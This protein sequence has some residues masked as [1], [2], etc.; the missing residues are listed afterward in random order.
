M[1][2]SVFEIIKDKNL[3]IDNKQFTKVSDFLSIEDDFI[4]SLN[5]IIP[6]KDI[7]NEIESIKNRRLLKR[8]L[9][10]SPKT[11]EGGK[12]E[13]LMSLGERP[14]GLRFIRNLISDRLTNV[15]PYDIWIDMPSPPRFPE[16][17]ECIVKVTDDDYLPLT[18]FFPASEW[19]SSYSINKYRG[20]IFCP[21]SQQSETDRIARFVLKEIYNISLNNQSSILAKH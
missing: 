19:S 5:K 11:I 10:L 8:A 1:I 17:A 9:V 20:H 4:Y 7:H 6:D 18:E 3:T 2:R 14:E 16:P 21:A 13:E 15:S 12:T